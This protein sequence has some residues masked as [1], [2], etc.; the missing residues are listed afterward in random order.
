MGTNNTDNDRPAEES[1]RAEAD[2]A[3]PTPVVVTPEI[4]PPSPAEADDCA[5][6]GPGRDPRPDLRGA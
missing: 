3:V 2:D 5:D 1:A 6:P 4:A